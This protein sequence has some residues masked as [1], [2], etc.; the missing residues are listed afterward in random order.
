MALAV[1]L[2]DFEPLY[3]TV[4]GV[5]FRLWIE[6]GGRKVCVE[7]PESV[8]VERAPVRAARL[9]RAAADTAVVPQAA[10]CRQHSE[11]VAVEECDGS[12][13]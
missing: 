13:D 11:A 1:K 7:A 3:I 10:I 8:R 9:A 4:G 2:A 12:P 6:R 5:E